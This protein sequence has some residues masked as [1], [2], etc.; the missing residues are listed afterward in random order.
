MVDV[1]G[2]VNEWEMAAAAVV[3]CRQLTFWTMRTMKSEE[4][5]VVSTAQ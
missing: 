3:I 1:F 2:V 5:V 4:V